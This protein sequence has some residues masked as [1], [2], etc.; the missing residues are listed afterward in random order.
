[1]D[2]FNQKEIATKNLPLEKGNFL[3]FRLLVEV[4]IRMENNI[5]AQTYLVEILNNNYPESQFVADFLQNYQADKAIEW[6]TRDDSC[7]LKELNKALRQQDLDRLFPFRCLIR[8]IYNELKAEHDEETRDNDKTITLYRKQ[9][10]SISELD[11]LVDANKDELIAVNSFMSAWSDRA[12]AVNSLQSQCE[13]GLV[14]V[15]FE[16]EVNYRKNSSPFATINENDGIMLFMLGCI[17]RI[18]SIAKDGTINCYVL[19]LEL[20]CDDDANLK[21]IF[22]YMT[23]AFI[24]PESD[25]ITL[26]SLLYRMGEFEKARKYYELIL[27]ELDEN[28]SNYAHCLD[29]LGYIENDQGRLNEALKCH[30]KALELRQKYGLPDANQGVI[31]LSYINIANAYKDM[32]QYKIA[33]DYV[34]KARTLIKK[35]NLPG[36]GAK[37][38]VCH[39]IEGSIL[40][41]EG[42][43][44]DALEQFHQAWGI[45]QQLGM[46]NDHPDLASIYQSMGLC[47]LNQGILG[48]NPILALN[49]LTEALDIQL[50]ALPYNHCRTGVT[51]RSLGLAYEQLQE[52]ST[53]IIFYQKAHTVYRASNKIYSE[54]KITEVD[55]ERIKK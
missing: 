45:N 3:W 36:D 53:A 14:C 52:Y 17:F 38:A 34:K 43:G 30:L 12:K 51:Y 49:Y 32:A 42:N 4:L 55:I 10:I 8:D 26:G 1:M 19:K 37:Q 6:F 27:S 50:K 31:V 13:D 20:C 54:L 40:Y 7:L 23:N 22:D 48:N 25:L 29:G 39:F 16:I 33:L 21:N 46:P 44:I 35:Q 15:L 47:H 41:N 18:R 5:P 11:Q 9:V 24:Q 28:E 2:V